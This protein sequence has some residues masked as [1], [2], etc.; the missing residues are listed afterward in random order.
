M[1]YLLLGIFDVYMSL[2][3]G[4]GRDNAGER[5]REAIDKKDKGLLSLANRIGYSYS[6]VINLGRDQIRGLFGLI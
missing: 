4:K 6:K 5:L 1:V 2:I 3:Y